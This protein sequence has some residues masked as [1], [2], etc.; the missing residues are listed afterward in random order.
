MNPSKLK[1]AWNLKHAAVSFV[2]WAENALIQTATYFA[3]VLSLK[4]L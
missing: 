2:L 3:Q 1:T 4:E